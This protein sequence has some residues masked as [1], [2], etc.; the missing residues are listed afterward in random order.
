MTTVATKVTD[1]LLSRGYK[2]TITSGGCWKGPDQIQFVLSR[3]ERF[4][5]TVE[6]LCYLPTPDKLKSLQERYTHVKF[7]VPEDT[8]ARRVIVAELHPNPKALSHSKGSDPEIGWKLH[9]RNANIVAGEDL[10]T[11]VNAVYWWAPLDSKGE[12]TGGTKM[13]VAIS[14][15]FGIQNVYHDYHT[16]HEWVDSL[17]HLD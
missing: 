10:A 15:R 11:P 6:F 16:V 13:G 17:K 9:G 2:V 4:R 7:V 8:P 3:L 12:P 1:M 14:A 5:D